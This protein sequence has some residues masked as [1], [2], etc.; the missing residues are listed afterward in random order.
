MTIGF[1]I[2]QL[3]L[4][5]PAWTE[6]QIAQICNCTRQWV[7][8]VLIKVGL[9]TRH[10]RPKTLLTCARCGKSFPRWVS[11]VERSKR[12]GLKRVYC[13]LN[14]SKLRGKPISRKEG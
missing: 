14:C 5:H 6:A 3:R 11:L 12:K 10:P 4:Q 2:I 9:T 13:S 7:S 8:L 1:H